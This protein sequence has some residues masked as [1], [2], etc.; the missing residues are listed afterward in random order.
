MPFSFP[1]LPKFWPINRPRQFFY[2]LT[3]ESKHTDRRTSY[4]N[5]YTLFMGH[6]VYSIPTDSSFS[7]LQIRASLNFHQ[8]SFFL[9]QVAI[10]TETHN[11]S[12]Y[13]EKVTVVLNGTYVSY[14][15]PPKAQGT[16]QKRKWEGYKNPE[17]VSIRKECFLITVVASGRGRVHCL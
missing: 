2:S 15:S 9:Q 4:T 8:S 1:R 3:N 12:R 5:Y 10:D 14:S 16:L 7:S 11:W 17:A 6:S 13:R